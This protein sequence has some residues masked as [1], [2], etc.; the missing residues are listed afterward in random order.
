[1]TKR[2]AH[3]VLLIGW[4]AADWKAIHPLMDEGKMP[5]LKHFIETGVMGNL[6]T[7]DPPLSPIMWTSIGTGKTADKHGVL[8]FTQ[9][10][11]DGKGIQPVMSTS[12][13]VKAV[14]N[15]L[16]QNGFKTHVVGWWPSHPAEPLN[17]VCVSDFYHKAHNMPLDQ[18]PMAPGTVHPERL[19]E[20]L[21]ELRVH[22]Q[23]LTANHILPFVP[24]AEK[25]NQE[26]DQRLW[27]VAKITAECASIHSAA[28]WIMEH[29]A[30]D[31]MAVY[32]DSIDHY[33]HGFM[34]FHPPHREGIPRE[35]YD[36]Y[37]NIVEGGYRF[38]DMMLSRLLQLAGE[39]T[40][41]I[42]CSDHG[43]YP[44]HLRPLQ[45][46]REPAGPAAEHS[47][48]GMVAL[49]G[50]GIKHDEL[51]FGSTLLDITPTILTLFGVPVA[52][53]MDGKPLLQAFTEDITPEFIDSWET[54]AGDCGMLQADKISDPWA[55]QEALDQLVALGYIEP[56]GKD[57]QKSVERTIRESKFYLARVYLH[58]NDYANALPILEELYANYPDQTR[59]GLRLAQ[60]YKVLELIPD[61]RRVTDEVIVTWKQQRIEE[62]KANIAKAKEAGKDTTDMKVPD[63]PSS[64]QLELLQG[65]LCLAE[66]KADSA[67]AHFQRAQKAMPRLP[68]LHLGIAQAHFKLKRWQDAEE[69]YF[70]ALEIDPDSAAAHHGLAQVYL[71]MRHFKEAAE[72]AV[73]SVGLQFQNPSAHY[74]LGEALLRL[75]RFAEAEQS[76]LR[77][78][79]QAPGMKRA[80]ERL[81]DLYQHPLNDPVKAFNHQQMLERI[82]PVS[83]RRAVSQVTE[84]TTVQVTA[85]SF[86]TTPNEPAKIITIVSG[87]PRSGTSM[88]MQLLQAGGLTILSDEQRVA[89]DS[90][91]KGYLE[92]EKVKNL[93]QDNTWL[94]DAQGKV[95][96]IIAH[97][98]PYLPSEYYYRIIF[99]QR[100]LEEVLQSQQTMLERLNTK[101][102]NPFHLRQTYTQ[103]LARLATW[104]TQQ[105]HITLLPLDHHVVLEQPFVIAQQLQLFLD[106][107]IDISSAIAVVDQQLYRVRKV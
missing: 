18:W 82:Q 81:I 31:F 52:R 104:L 98:L 55:D 26:K 77:A 11:P 66:E 79:A 8:G 35:L 2:L 28:T 12:R 93:S 13:K 39:N 23:E 71:Q 6:A 25:V 44:D 91:P 105:D 101:K 61:A 41:V 19:A 36:L 75:G 106:Y 103:Q 85:K 46:P 64:P 90:N 89:D 43:F 42:I 88:M 62:V 4:D 92:Y 76:W 22:P 99:M 67:L 27:S 17:G 87:L 37:H 14:W 80:H 5:T 40:T 53:D 45:L 7:L 60:C 59:F 69:A 70:Q 63:D 38:H 95:V 48:Y 47:P 30:W 83:S 49:R 86:E 68:D 78:V 97:L 16:M 65:N 3:K 33:C 20:T 34:K 56:P 107:P 32:F 58:K 24:E 29:E 96:K 21:A 9:P 51:I 50:P 72:A 100:D 84:S 10:R 1:M 57:A 54:V 94:G 74:H 102:S 73:T 15:I